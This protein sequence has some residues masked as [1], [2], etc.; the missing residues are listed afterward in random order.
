MDVGN[1]IRWIARALATALR[2]AWWVCETTWMG[3]TTLRRFATVI[4]L[5]REA[6]AEQL[7]CPRGHL[8]SVFG[9][10]DCRCGA[11]H[12]GWAFGQCRVCGN[13]A[14]WTPCPTCGLPVVNPF[15][16]VIAP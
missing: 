10:Y 6:N 9:V 12:E 11:I 2:A 4:R 1:A 8:V 15:R 5:L 16:G 3:A 13:G 14:G 7:P